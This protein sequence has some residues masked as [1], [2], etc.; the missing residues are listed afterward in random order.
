LRCLIGR[1]TWTGWKKHP[2]GCGTPG[3]DH[4]LRHCTHCPKW[5]HRLGEDGKARR[6]KWGGLFD[7][8]EQT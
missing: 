1:H 6:F 7:R 8:K 4:Y 3:C 5:Q 2:D